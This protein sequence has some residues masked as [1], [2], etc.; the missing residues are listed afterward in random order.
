MP[1]SLQEPFRAIFYTPFYAAFALGA[2][3]Q[4]GLDVRLVTPDSWISAATSIISGSVDVTWGGPM[5]VMLLR[6][7]DPKVRLVCFGAVVIRDPFY[8]VGRR[9]NPGYRH[10]DL[11]GLR[12]ASTSEVPTPWMC[13]QEDL[14]QHGI[15]PSKLT[16][17]ADRPMPQNAEDLLADRVDVVQ[18]LEPFATQLEMS[19][20]GHVWYTQASRGLCSYTSFY[21]NDDV[22]AARRD[23]LK[24]MTRAIA[25][26]L[27]WVGRS[28]ASEIADVVGSHFTHVPRE[29]LTR[30]I[31][32]YKRNQL[33]CEV[34]I[35]P[36]EAF[37]RLKAG[38]LS[39]GLIA[40]DKPFDV[41]V[42]NSLAEEIITE[43]Y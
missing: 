15:D 22:I 7:R 17:I 12:F 20:V 10:S 14:R 33:W 39:G 18:V 4:E 21:A 9:P 5:R 38:L 43:G 42:D 19:G 29:V 13:F 41:C 37:D 11:L 28:D 31:A 8:L 23:E 1:I 34:P 16:R 24:R 2:F 30:S 26:T 6:D 25:R 32:R 3:R 36:R 35:L 40:T 27:R